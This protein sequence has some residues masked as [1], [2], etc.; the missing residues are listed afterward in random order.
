MNFSFPPSVYYKPPTRPEGLRPCPGRGN[1][2][3]LFAFC[4][5]YFWI[6]QQPILVVSEVPEIFGIQIQLIDFEFEYLENDVSKIFI[7]EEKLQTTYFSLKCKFRC[8]LSLKNDPK[9]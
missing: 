9:V 8:K 4:P 7:V 2:G 3:G 6:L 1:A 5:F